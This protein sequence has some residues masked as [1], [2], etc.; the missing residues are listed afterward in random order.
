[1][2]LAGDRV[3][4]AGLAGCNA[5]FRPGQM[6]HSSTGEARQAVEEEAQDRLIGTGAGQMKRDAGL[7]R[8]DAHGELHE[9]QPEGIELRDPPA[10]ALRHEAAQR[11]QDPVSARVQQSGG[12]R[13]RSPSCTTSGP[14]A[15]WRFHALMWFSA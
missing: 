9:A 6:P 13:W 2:L 10:G 8:D 3:L 4:I 11:P 14:A 5:G 12:T 15:R 7:Q 1:M